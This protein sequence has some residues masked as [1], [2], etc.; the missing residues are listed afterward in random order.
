MLKESVRGL[1]QTLKWQN[2]EWIFSLSF[3]VA[4]Q[5][6]PEADCSTKALHFSI[7]F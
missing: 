2:H 1:S 6:T 3:K 5:S 7:R 4:F